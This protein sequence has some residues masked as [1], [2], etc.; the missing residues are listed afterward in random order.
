MLHANSAPKPAQ[1]LYLAP[2]IDIYKMPL[3]IE[4]LV[5]V[6]PMCITHL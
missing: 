3:L 2:K 5:V 4:G 1:S 6:N